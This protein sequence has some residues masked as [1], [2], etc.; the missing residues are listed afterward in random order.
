MMN[1]IRTRI[2]AKRAAAQLQAIYAWRPAPRPLRSSRTTLPDDA[3]HGQRRGGRWPARRC[4]FRTTRPAWSRSAPDGSVARHDARP[5]QAGADRPDRLRLPRRRQP[6]RRPVREPRRHPL[7]A[8]RLRPRSPRE[9]RA[10]HGDLRARVGGG[11]RP[12]T[13]RPRPGT[14]YDAM[15][16]LRRPV[17]RATT[18]GRCSARLTTPTSATVVADLV[19]AWI[20]ALAPV[21]AAR[22]P[23]R[24]WS[25]ARRAE[26]RARRAPRGGAGAA[27]PP[28]A[29]P[30]ARSRPSSPPASRCRSPPA[31]GC[32]RGSA[33]HPSRRRR[34]R[35]RRVGDAAP[36]AADLDHRSHRDRG[37]RAG[38]A[39]GAVRVRVVL[40]SPLL[41]GRDSTT[42]CR[43]T[44]RPRRLRPRPLVRRRPADRGPGCRSAQV[45]TPARA[46]P[47]A[48]AQLLR[49]AQWA[50][51]PENRVERE[52][53]D[54][55]ESGHHAHTV[56]IHRR[57]QGDQQ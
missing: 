41:L 36:D 50:T 15:L 35:A 13:T 25:R 16:L 2:E 30:A 56:S 9:V 8:P 22:R 43:A 51:H 11:A 38:R 10:R 55:P 23:P 47:S 4:P 49:L 32:S 52:G 29:A 40:V 27:H 17:A 12:S 21:I 45:R 19:L 42:S 26:S 37:R 33:E 24:R 53:V 14:P 3:R 1:R 48:T 44:T 18:R 34:P 54:R 28:P 39:A 31:P 46:A 5:R 57:G 6:Q 20:D 7:G